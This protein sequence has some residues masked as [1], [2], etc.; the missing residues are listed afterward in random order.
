MI[1]WMLAF[2]ILQNPEST[3]ATVLYSAV[4]VAEWAG[5]LPHYHVLPASAGL[6]ETG[7]YVVAQCVAVAVTAFLSAEGTSALIGVLAILIIVG[8]GWMLWRLAEL[9]TTDQTTRGL[10]VG[11]AIAMLGGDFGE[12]GHAD[13]VGAAVAD[14]GIITGQHAVKTKAGSFRPGS[15]W[16]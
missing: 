15:A 10:I 16:P 14:L 7:V 3:L 6:A 13:D 2:P 8:A 4:V 12:C 1:P 9:A 11:A 5:V